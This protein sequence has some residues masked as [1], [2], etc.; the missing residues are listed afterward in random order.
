MHTKATKRLKP[1]FTVAYISKWA[2]VVSNLYASFAIFVT[3]CIVVVLLTQGMFHTTNVTML[4]QDTWTTRYQSCRLSASGF[5][6]C[7]PADVAVTGNAPWTSIGLQLAAEIDLQNA[8]AYVTTCS[9]ISAISDTQ[10]VGKLFLV[11]GETSFPSCNP[12]GPQVVTGM[13]VVDT[14]GTTDFP[15]G[16][17]LV[18]LFSDAKAIQ[19][20]SVRETNGNMVPVTA[21]G[22]KTI[23]TTDG[24]RVPADWNQTNYMTSL[25]S[26]NR[27][28]LMRVFAVNHFLDMSSAV[29]SM[30]GYSVGKKTG[31]IT[32]VGVANS[33]KV[34][35]YFFLFVF[36]ITLCV[37]TL[38]M[39]TNDF[40]ITLEGLRGL[41]RNKPVL[42]Y[43]LLASLE[44]RK[45]LLLALVASF[46]FSPLYIDVIC[47]TYHIKGYTYWSVLLIMI[48]LSL[49]LSWI[50]ILTC[51]VQWLPVPA[52]WRNKP[53]CYSAPFFVYFHSI[54]F[55]LTEAAQRRGAK[56][57]ANF[58]GYAP[59]TL[60]LNFDG[61]NVISGAFKLDGAT[62]A[63]YTLMP[64]IAIIFVLAWFGS[65]ATYK[66]LTGNIV[67][68]T[69]WTAQNE[70]LKQL[71]LP[72]WVTALDLDKTNTI[73]IGTKLY[74]RPSLIVLFG[75]CTVHEDI[76]YRLGDDA[77]LNVSNNA[78]SHIDGV[79]STSSV[80]LSGIATRG[81][82]TTQSHYPG[83][84]SKPPPHEE[85][86]YMVISIYGL[87]ATTIPWIRRIYQTKIFGE[88]Y[89]N[90]FTQ[91]KSIT[92]INKALNY[93]YSRGDCCN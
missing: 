28:F 51:I 24:A 64:D 92:H 68:D 40:M 67:L 54:V 26:L 52:A 39:L 55:V 21:S 63:I 27:I 84:T 36:Q 81:K 3:G 10:S 15:D 4:T 13:A 35:N 6:A 77:H 11:V 72:Q 29:K 66:A 25:N 69:T 20:A 38:L 8:T 80:A 14:V 90:K 73:A 71:T 57:S 12:V 48:S 18:S 74:C 75:F 41:L 44:R 5:T 43:D 53:I 65:I 22:T 61:T 85:T 86:H 34:D 58:W 83:Q 1:Q 76:K 46:C 56:S 89:Q 32:T 78:S 59:S 50:A 7:D 47:F 93:V 91:V 82:I 60:R 9:L 37:V 70:F 30:Q 16:A 87:V 88:I 17:F 49:T 42:T 79:E 33:H 19:P 62:P 23:V 45:V 31:F 2:R